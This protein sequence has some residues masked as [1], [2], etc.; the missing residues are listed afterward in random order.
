MVKTS[1]AATYLTGN[2]ISSLDCRRRGPQPAM[3]ADILA[4]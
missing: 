1:A 3:A 4:A 2:I